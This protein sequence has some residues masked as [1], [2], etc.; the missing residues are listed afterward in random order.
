MTN[1]RKGT[2]LNLKL[3][4]SENQYL[5]TTKHDGNLREQDYL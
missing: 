4:F 2:F 5:I 3:D 1:N